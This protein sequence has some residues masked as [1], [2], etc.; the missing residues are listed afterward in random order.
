M[1]NQSVPVLKWVA[2]EYGFVPKSAEEE[3][4]QAYFYAT[5]DEYIQADGSMKALFNAE[6]EDEVVQKTTDAILNKLI[7]PLEAR[8]AD[9]RKFTAGE[10]ATAADFRLLAL[11]TAIIDNPNGRNEKVKAVVQPAYA[12]ATNLKRV[13]EN[14][15]GLGG[16]KDYLA[17][18]AVVG[19]V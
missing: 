18:G 9:G 19:H 17:S 6:A 2:W 3:Y 7:K 13:V 8:F 5:L 10:N 14:I 16:L 1:I 12:E 11:I 15:T 4:Q